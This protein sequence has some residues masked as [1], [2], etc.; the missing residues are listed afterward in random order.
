MERITHS[1]QEQVREHTAT[2][3]HHGRHRGGREQGSTATTQQTRRRDSDTQEQ[4]H[5]THRA[6]TE[7]RTSPYTIGHRGVL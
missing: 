7:E 3:T 5:H 1:K 2:H 6:H 4:A